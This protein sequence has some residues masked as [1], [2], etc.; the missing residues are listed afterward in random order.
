MYEQHL[1]HVPFSYLSLRSGD[2]DVAHAVFPTDALAAARWGRRTGRPSVL[3]YMGVP[4]R[5]WL[6][7]ARLRL[8]VLQRALRNCDAV[9][10][11]SDA[12]ARSFR[13]VLGADVRVI[14]PGVN[15]EAFSLAPARH[16]EPTIVCAADL[17]EPRKRVDMLIEAFRIVRRDRPGARLVLSRPRDPAVLARYNGGLAGV[18]L[19][20]LDDR[21]ALAG[22][23]GEAW[24]S[25]LP[26][27]N[28]AFGLV[29][30][31]AMAC[32]TP[33]VATRTG[34]MPEV[35][36]GRDDV[37]RLF[38]GGERELARALAEAL[39]LAEDPA[40]RAACRARAEQLSTAR[41]AREYESLYREL[42][43]S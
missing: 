26:S 38:E 16:P 12:A 37:G 6:I 36:G 20:D 7:R 18:E 19:A 1:T 9:I 23:Y 29:L 21:A 17:G 22:A 40:T 3:S 28:E 43:A 31:E 41:C 8:Q 27:T 42:A 33:V 24:V 4:E 39:E 2:D 11:L 25:A 10:A 32:G 5:R 15:L 34:G 14:R 30:A 35:L 13:R